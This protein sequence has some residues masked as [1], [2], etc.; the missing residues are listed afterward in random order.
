MILTPSQGLTEITSLLSLVV[1]LVENLPAMKETLVRF[2]GREDLLAKG[3]ATLSSV[4][5][6]RIPWTV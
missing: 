4:L 1:Q 3:T 2:L 6:W 5:A